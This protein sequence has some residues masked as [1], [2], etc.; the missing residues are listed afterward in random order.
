M[1]ALAIAIALSA[2]GCLDGTVVTSTS[3]DDPCDYRLYHDPMCDRGGYS[4]NDGY[5]NPMHVWIAPHY[6]HRTVIVSPVYRTTT[7][8]PSTIIVNRPAVRQRTVVQTTTVTTTRSR[9]RV[10]GRSI[11]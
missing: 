2:V 9:L 11:R 8:H 7:Y 4:W 5:Y 10:N 3:L 1:R 6:T